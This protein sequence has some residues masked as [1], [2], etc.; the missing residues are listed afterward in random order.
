MSNEMAILTELPDVTPDETNDKFNDSNQLRELG[1][2]YFK[3]GQLEK[4]ADSYIKLL[5]LKDSSQDDK[6]IGHKNLAAVYLKQNKF[7]DALRESDA[8]LLI[9]GQDV[10]ALFRRCQALEGLGRFGEALKDGLKVQHL[11][12][13]NQAIK[14]VLERINVKM[15]SK[16]KEDA[17]TVNRVTSMFKYVN[18]PSMDLEKREQAVENLIVLSRESENGAQMI[19]Q[20]NGVSLLRKTIESNLKT[21]PE[22][23]I[24]GIRVLSELCKGSDERSKLVLKELGGVD[25]FLVIL[26][27]L[28]KDDM[29][30]SIQYTI[31]VALS[32]LSGYDLRDPSKSHNEILLKKNEELVDSI[33]T[34]L[35]NYSV[36]RTMSGEA[37]DAIIE[38]IMR[39]VEYEACDWATKVIRRN[40]LCKL[41]EVASEL[42]EVKY[43]SS[44]DITCNT[45][46]HVALTLERV[47]G[48]LHSDK[49]REAYRNDVQSYLQGLLKSS[50]IESKVRAT[51]VITT[52]L[53][54]PIDVGNHCLA[55]PGLV[56]MML[57]MAGSDDD[58]VQQKVA[59]EAIIA[60]ASKK[61]KC[62][63]IVGM[64]TKILKKLYSSPNDAI[65]VRGLVGLC[66]LGSVGGT[67]A[68]IKPFSDESIHKLVTACRKFLVNPTKSTDLKKWAAEGYAY[69]TLD[70]EVKEE[71]VN[72]PQVVHALID[73]GKSGNLSCLYGIITTLV[74][75]TNSYEKNE[76]LPE[77]I[78]LAKF[79]KQ[80][81]PEEHIKDK[82]E[83]IDKRVS[84]LAEM[85]V[86]SA[87]TSLS[88]TESPS[89]RELISR[90]FNAICEQKELRGRV[91]SAGGAKAL[92]NMALERNTAK[93]KLQ[94]AQALAR[95]GITMNPEVA[96]PGQRCVEVVRPIM[97]LLHIECTA[98]QNFEALMALTNL[99]TISES[100]RD[101]IM[102][103]CGLSKIENYMFEEHEMLR[104][105]ATQCVNNL[106]THK[107]AIEAYEGENDRVKMLVVLSEEDDLETG[108]AALGALAMLTSESKKCAR[109]VFEARRWFE[110]L[111]MLSSSKDKELQH[112]AII[113]IR[114][115]MDADKESAEKIVETPIF[116]VLMA[117]VRPEVDDIE[118]KVK[119][120][121]RDALSKAKEYNLI[122]NTEETAEGSDDEPD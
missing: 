13:K 18:D 21:A 47:Y 75:L 6:L 104:R 94:A 78:E 16:A 91:V 36:K 52:L 82:K 54:G 24:Q 67:D 46:S 72:D 89:A 60:A 101:R 20:N 34:S 92:L 100:V 106:I 51:A 121:A 118:E 23:S 110:I 33:M 62:T 98:L 39:N 28:K 43:E 45:R 57:V 14:P 19:L 107:H 29:I 40:L 68:A 108:K 103:D 77:M 97:Q 109:K 64:G 99:S 9:N 3:N 49:D 90:V 95:I 1:N 35:L 42:E 32:S 59:A 85:N 5:R 66:K 122:R 15:Q 84:K 31:Q 26:R 73:L 83:Y 102:K 117:L 11:E 17:K 80:H 114:N 96:F 112:R 63:S 22:I 69:L 93:G 70:A 2:Q 37:R 119:Q 7:E 88:K 50:D 61:D 111:L 12:P 4:A 8:A 48:S 76:V 74:N 65:K 71:V 10:K 115:I 79:A 56:E 27:D 44:M 116:E 58:E 53:T 87:L 105:A 30:T 38:V 41:L 86:A 113:V 81:I 120:I 55:Q 25:F